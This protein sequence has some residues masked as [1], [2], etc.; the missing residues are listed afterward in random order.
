MNADTAAE[1]TKCNVSTCTYEEFIAACHLTR[2]ENCGTGTLW[3]V[4]EEYNLK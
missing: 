3:E 2:T 4:L 1:E